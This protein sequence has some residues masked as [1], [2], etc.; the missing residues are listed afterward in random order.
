MLSWV[1]DGGDD[2]MRL[3]LIRGTPL[4]DTKNQ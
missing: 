4:A 3:G 1:K 2:L